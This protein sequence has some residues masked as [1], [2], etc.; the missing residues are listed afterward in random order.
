MCWRND[1]CRMYQRSVRWAAT[2]RG[3]RG[4][5]RSSHVDRGRLEA[6]DGDVLGATAVVEGP[7]F[8]ILGEDFVWARIGTVER[9]RGRATADKNVGGGR[10]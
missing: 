8:V 9:A 3:L 2:A 5:Y 4:R 7:K 6:V 10:Q 1:R